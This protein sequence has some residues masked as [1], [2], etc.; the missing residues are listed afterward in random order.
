MNTFQLISQIQHLHP[1]NN[2]F[3]GIYSINN[4]DSAP[5][6][7][8]LY[9]ICNTAPTWSRGEH[10]IAIYI[11]NNKYG[12]FFDS[13]GRE[14]NKHF[15]RF[16]YSRCKKI[17]HNKKKL[18]GLFSNT[19]GAWC[20]YFLLYR[21]RGYSM[22]RIVKRINDKDMLSWMVNILAVNRDVYVGNNFVRNNQITKIRYKNVN[23]EDFV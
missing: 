10:W 17:V 6:V 8:P 21:S 1:L 4:I 5:F 22:N 18:Q 15:K 23:K 14:P 16:M 19:C 2:L 3:N 7:Y 9:I 13:Y 20:L 11:I 12:E